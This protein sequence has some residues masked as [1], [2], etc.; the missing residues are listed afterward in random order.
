[1][2][3]VE[4]KFEVGDV[5]K[6]I[7]LPDT[8]SGNEIVKIDRRAKKVYYKDGGHDN[9]WIVN[10]V[11]EKINVDKEDEL[12]TGWKS[13]DKMFNGGFKKGELFCLTAAS[14]RPRNTQLRGALVNNGIL[15]LLK[16]MDIELNKKG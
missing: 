15:P 4:C 11:Y 7:G 3:K 16:S 2:A 10:S 9:L 1:M 5:I 13:V 14:I 6:Q 8:F 12:D